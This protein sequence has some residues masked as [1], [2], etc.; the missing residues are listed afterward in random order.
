M[1][2]KKSFKKKETNYRNANDEIRIKERRKDNNKKFNKRNIYALMEEEDDTDIDLYA[3][4]ND[5]E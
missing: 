3:Y 4:L 1:K 2:S 5:E